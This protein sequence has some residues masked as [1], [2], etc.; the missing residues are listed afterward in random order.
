MQLPTLLRPPAVSLPPMYTWP[1]FIK[2]SV[3]VVSVLLVIA[4][5]AFL[6]GGVLLILVVLAER[7]S[8]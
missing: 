6:T 2:R 1:R 5:Y 7:M 4:A 3:L 8:G